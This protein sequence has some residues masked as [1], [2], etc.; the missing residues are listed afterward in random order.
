MYTRM[1]TA[2]GGALGLLLT[3]VLIC[4]LGSAGP[5]QPQAD[6]ELAPPAG[7]TYVGAKRCSVCHFEEFTAWNKD[8]HSKSFELL[9]A[10][11]QKDPKCLK[12]HATG[13]GEPSG[14]KDI[15]S[16]PS[17]AGN[18]CE[19]CH[20]PGSKHEEVCKPFAKRKPNPAER[21]Q[22]KDTIWEM[23]PKNVCVECHRKQAHK[24]TDPP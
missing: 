16:T 11:S 12:C 20:G 8:K 1:R 17:L 24:A 15:E 3:V 10:K 19:T 6:R 2:V 9:E 23:L 22:A 18:T 14:F 5:A 13:Y 21:K 7:Q 4:V